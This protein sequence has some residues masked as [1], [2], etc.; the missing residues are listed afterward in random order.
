VAE[1]Q[2]SSNEANLNP[3]SHVQGRLC[4][5]QISYID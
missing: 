4:S 3:E 1:T 2:L 5:M